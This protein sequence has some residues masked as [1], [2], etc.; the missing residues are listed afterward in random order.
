MKLTRVKIDKTVGGT[1]WQLIRIS[2]L[3][4]CLPSNIVLCSQIQPQCRETSPNILNNDI[5]MKCDL[6]CGVCAACRPKYQRH[7]DSIYPQDVTQVSVESASFQSYA[8]LKGIVRSNL[9]KL[10]FYALTKP[11]KLDKIGA[12]LSKRIGNDIYRCF[13]CAFC[14]YFQMYTDNAG[15]KCWSVAKRWISC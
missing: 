1:D 5:K 10:T 2:Q 11:E 4:A 6:S 8:F 9:Q 12:Y 7:V 3:Y 15:C 13:A 14:L